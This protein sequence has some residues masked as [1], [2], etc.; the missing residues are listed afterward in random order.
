[1]LK[2]EYMYDDYKQTLV[3]ILGASN[4]GEVDKLFEEIFFSKRQTL[5]SFR[6]LYK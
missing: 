2:V 6:P 4:Q 3:R 5:N 1:M